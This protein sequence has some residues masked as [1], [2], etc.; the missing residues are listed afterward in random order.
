MQIAWDQMDMSAAKMATCV[1]RVSSSLNQELFDEWKKGNKNG[2][3]ARLLTK[4]QNEIDKHFKRVNGKG[5]L[6]DF[7]V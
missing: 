5:A 4:A 7:S 2:V 3:K 1:D 6:V